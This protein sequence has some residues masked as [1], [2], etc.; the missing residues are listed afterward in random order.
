MTALL[1]TSILL[2]TGTVAAAQS[3]AM[4]ANSVPTAGPMTHCHHH[5]SDMAGM[6]DMKMEMDSAASQQQVHC[7]DQQPCQCL[8]LCQLGSSILPT[9]LSD[10]EPP[11][12]HYIAGQVV[13]VS[14]GIHRL[15]LRPPSLTV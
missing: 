14:P 6:T 2:V 10:Q 12:Q 11:L 3:S 7:P 15:P 9:V 5:S 8:T 1:L 4:A 13:D